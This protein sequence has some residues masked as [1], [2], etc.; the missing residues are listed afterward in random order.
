MKKQLIYIIVF[1]CICLIPSVGFLLGGK[2][3][4]DENK[5]DNKIPAL[6]DE[7]GK[8]NINFFSDAGSWFEKN[9]AFRNEMVTAHAVLF[10][11]CFGMSAQRG[12]IAG[13]NGYLYY[14]DSLEDYQGKLMSRR[15]LF[16]VAHTLKMIQDYAQKSGVKFIF[17]PAPNKNSL[18]GENMPY[19]YRLFAGSEKNLTL[20]YDYLDAEGVNYADLRGAL[21]EEGSVLYH[22]RDSHWNNE[23]AA[24]ASDEVMDELGK[25]HKSYRGS[26]FHVSRDFEGDLDRMLFPAYIRPEDEIYYEPM[27]EFTYDEEI[28]SNFEPRIHTNSS[29][30][31]NLLMYRDSFGNALLPFF[32]EAYGK[33]YFSRS[34]PYYLPDLKEHGA[35][36]LVIER[37]E[38]FLPEMA[39]QPPFMEAPE[40]DSYTEGEADFVPVI[41]EI[42]EE[43]K[44]VRI[45]GTV[46]KVEY[47][48][49]ILIRINSC[50]AEAEGSKKKCY[51]AFPYTNEDGEECY[52]AVFGK[53]GFLYKDAAYEIGLM[54]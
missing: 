17:A 6:K 43:G 41:P 15:Q 16:Q 37:A 44:Y 13:K 34:L 19:F 14:R 35:D 50:F 47:N 23:G 32:A 5:K 52:T 10:Y 29:G 12:V 22:K 24:I 27:P 4:M 9:F 25:E 49:R 48:T 40:V 38:R 30:S 1:L 42:K 28:E 11:R 31:G 2:S 51:E 53:E 46:D 36:T 18:Y 33:A 3:G 8:I 21:L 45:F 26:P 20:L 54:E 39:T 7:E